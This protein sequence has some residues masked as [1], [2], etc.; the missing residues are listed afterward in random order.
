MLCSDLPDDK[1]VTM[2]LGH[3]NACGRKITISFAGHGP[4][5]HWISKDNSFR[6]I[7]Q[8]NLPL[9]VVN[10]YEATEEKIDLDK[11]DFLLLASDGFYEW[12]NSKG[13]NFG[14]ARFIESAT[15]SNHLPSELLLAF[16]HKQAKEWANNMF[17]EDD[18]SAM[19][20]RA[21]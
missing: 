21:I 20:I 2:I 19:L 1:F 12:P 9:G 6:E 5:Y 11:E 13:E 10:S 16:L 3:I 7:V 17:P 18:L 14:N 8:R 15:K 4:A